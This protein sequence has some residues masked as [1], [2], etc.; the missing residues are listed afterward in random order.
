LV[1]KACDYHWDIGYFSE[2]NGS[3]ADKGT[4][5]DSQLSKIAEADV[6]SRKVRN[7]LLVGAAGLAIPMSYWVGHEVGFARGRN[8]MPVLRPYPSSLGE[9][10]RD[11]DVD[12]CL[13]TTRSRNLVE[14]IGGGIIETIQGKVE[15]SGDARNLTPLATTALYCMTSPEWY[16]DISDGNQDVWRILYR[17]SGISVP[18]PKVSAGTRVTVKIRGHLGFGKAAGFMMSDALGPV[19]AAEQGAFGQ[20][21]DLDDEKP[22]TIRV[23]E[24]IGM[25]H[26]M[27][28]DAVI[29]A[30][31]ILGDTAAKVLPGRIG[32]VSL[33]ANSYH[34]WNALTYSWTNERCTDMFDQSSWLL[35]RT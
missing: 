33:G 22:F 15:K 24:A 34:F 32:S 12:V 14:K 18:S 11:I 8:A 29:H 17:A 28:G 3:W 27:C 25:K 16:I 7:V 1:G 19:L 6:I 4:N 10:G 2:D 26:E 31:E 21:L 13:Q 9:P 30:I 23:N 20:G 35:W 5:H